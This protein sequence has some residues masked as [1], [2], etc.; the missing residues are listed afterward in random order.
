MKPSWDD[1]PKWANWLAMD[2][3]GMWFWFECKPEFEPAAGI[4]GDYWKPSMGRKQYGEENQ[5]ASV[6]TLEYR[7]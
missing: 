7:P 5:S 1:A 6:N 3:D 4:Y 2:G